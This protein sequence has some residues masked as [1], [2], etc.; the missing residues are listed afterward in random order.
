MSTAPS[1]PVSS[2]VSNNRVYIRRK[3][4]KTQP[5]QKTK[6]IATKEIIRRRFLLKNQLKLKSQVTTTNSNQLSKQNKK[7][8]EIE[9]S[10]TSPVLTNLKKEST[11][12]KKNNLTNDGASPIAPPTNLKE[13]STKVET[14]KQDIK[15]DATSNAASNA[16]SDAKSPAHTAT[17]LPTTTTKPEN[18]VLEA[19]HCPHCQG[20]LSLTENEM[21]CKIFRHGWL[22]SNYSQI[23][24][25]ASKTE[26]DYLFKN[27]LIIGCGKP[28]K[29]IDR[30]AI[31][32]DY[33]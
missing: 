28:F 25:H 13:A 32:C 18:T 17:S 11:D 29:V 12:L 10:E 19:L 33:I 23:P 21:N 8:K 31:S 7:E 6:E 30:K 4:F 14:P 26:C 24:P 16:A 1:K 20:E 5:V 15:S 9:K 3:P 2:T 22:R 27:G